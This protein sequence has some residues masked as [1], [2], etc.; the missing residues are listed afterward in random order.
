MTDEDWR[1]FVMETAGSVTDPTFVRH[2]Q[3]N[4]EQREEL[5]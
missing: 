2:E 5:P 1:R 4:Y 3:G